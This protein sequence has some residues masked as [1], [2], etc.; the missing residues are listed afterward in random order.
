MTEIAFILDRSGSMAGIADETIATFQCFLQSQQQ[1][2]DEH[3]EPMP[4]RFSLITFAN[5]SEVLARRLPIQ[6]IAPLTRE[7]YIPNGG[8]ALLDTIAETIDS[9]GADL[10]AM[11][12]QEHPTKVIVAILTDGEENSSHRYSLRDVNQRI[13]HQT[14]VYQWEFLYLGADH[15]AIA[16]AARMGIEARN[17]VTIEKSS[18]SSGKTLRAVSKKLS[19]SR[20]FAEGVALS[21]EEQCTLQESICE[22]YEKTE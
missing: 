6:E 3:G 9:L 13:T 5:T 21:Q 1:L 4:A 10:A 12:K 7:N 11:P 15:D 22:T 18:I 20:K 8:T 14:Q 16:S 17:S 19:A 2:T